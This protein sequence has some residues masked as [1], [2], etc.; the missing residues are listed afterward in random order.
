MV[1]KFHTVNSGGP[2]LENYFSGGPGQHVLGWLAEKAERSLLVE[3][4]N[5]GR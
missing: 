3:I 2:S 1:A 4:N 5:M